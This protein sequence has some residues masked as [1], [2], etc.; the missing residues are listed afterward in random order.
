MSVTKLPAFVPSKK[1]LNSNH[2]EVNRQNTR[3]GRYT[4]IAPVLREPQSLV[5]LLHQYLHLNQLH[6]KKCELPRQISRQ[7]KTVLQ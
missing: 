2:K 7:F 6:S 4:G 3:Q 1:P 5:L